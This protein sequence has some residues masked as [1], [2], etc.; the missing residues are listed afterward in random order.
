MRNERNLQ[1]RRVVVT[2]AAAG[3]GRAL[4]RELRRVYRCRLE[5]VDRDMEGLDRLVRELQE[6]PAA[7]SDVRARVC[8]VASAE[9]VR[10]LAASLGDE[11]VDVLVNSAGAFYSGP[12]ETMRMEDFERLVAVNVTG[13]VRVVRALLPVLLR[14]ADP[15]VVNLSSLSGLHGAPGMCAYSTTKFAVVGFSESL[16]E[17]LA[18]RAE[19]C[20]VCPA[21]VRTDIA[22]NALFDGDGEDRTQR[23]RRMEA[24]LD[25]F[26][27][28]PESVARAV[29]RAV[30]ERR[31]RV[32]PDVEAKLLDGL[33]SVAPALGRRLVAAAHRE[34]VRRG[35]A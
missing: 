17:E 16:R 13:T 4:A 12:F 7:A 22:R 20:V 24:F 3:I 5:L 31:P 11:P 1:G 2:G 26:G 14:S 6:S 9:S 27:A 23:V 35:I 18:G 29:V 21:F 10:G 15:C 30:R 8:D 34:M 28:S 33:Y 25:R 19:V 32:L